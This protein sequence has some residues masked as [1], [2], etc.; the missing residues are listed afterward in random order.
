MKT[1]QKLAEE[2]KLKQSER[3]CRSQKF[4]S[5]ANPNLIHTTTLFYG[6][7]Q[8]RP[9]MGCTCQKFQFGVPHWCKHCDALWAELDG[10][11][12]AEYV[13]HDEVEK[14]EWYKS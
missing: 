10:W 12:R 14:K 7:T 4:R 5:K 1:A 9:K 2:W 11:H 6:G 3:V 8:D 13:H